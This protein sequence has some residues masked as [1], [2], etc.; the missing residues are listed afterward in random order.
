M[1]KTNFTFNLLMALLTF[2][3]TIFLL[4]V[5]FYKANPFADSASNSMWI[6]LVPIYLVIVI[7]LWVALLK[8]RK[9]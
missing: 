5:S 2:L 4:V 9:Q 6:W 8:K 1:K 3:G 7:S